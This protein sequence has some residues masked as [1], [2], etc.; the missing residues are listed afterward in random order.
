MRKSMKT[1]KEE[2]FDGTGKLFNS[3]NE[4]VRFP[5]SCAKISCKGFFHYDITDASV[6]HKRVEDLKKRAFN[7]EG[8]ADCIGHYMEKFG[9]YP[10]TARSLEKL[11]QPN[12]AVVIGGQQAGLL[13]GRFIPSIN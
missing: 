5:L 13:T 6:F 1:R 7:R 8:L 2:S 3:S 4:S 9:I 12:A 10:E 11:R